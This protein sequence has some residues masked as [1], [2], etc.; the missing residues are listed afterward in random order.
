MKLNIN[1]QIDV[2]ENYN[3]SE[4]REKYLKNETP[5]VLR[6]LWKD[7]PAMKKWSTG[8]FKKTLGH[9]D[10]GVFEKGRP[11]GSAKK[12]E[13]F[14]K[15][16]DYLNIIEHEPSNLR[17]F[18]FNIFKHKPDLKN[19]FDFN[20]IVR[21]YYKWTPFMFFGGKGAVVRLHYDID[22]PNLF[23]TQL[24]GRKLV[25]LFKNNYSALL[26]RV[27]FNVHSEVNIEKPDY[28]SY[29]GLQYVRGVTTILDPGDTLFIPA[30]YFHY[31][32]YLEGG[33]AINQRFLSKHVLKGLWNIGLLTHFDELMLMLLGNNWYNYKKKLC[34]LR[35]DKSIKK[36]KK[37][38]S[39]SLEPI[40]H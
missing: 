40:W 6:G 29:P 20:P 24:Y 23:L 31:I 34:F 33:F 2:I 10:V 22:W 19:D 35:A 32:K 37:E 9:I 13:K 12:P 11:T 17:L 38:I 7:Y 27:P 39:K 16:K 3:P 25:V 15:F 14:M 18:A 4:F 36:S 30:G 21:N 1:E 8:Y 28:V 5:V 26:Y